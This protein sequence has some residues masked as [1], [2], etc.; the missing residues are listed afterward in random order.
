MPPEPSQRRPSTARLQPTTPDPSRDPAFAIEHDADGAIAAVHSTVRL[1]FPEA[2]AKGLVAAMDVPPGTQVVLHTR[3]T[4]TGLAR[5]KARMALDD[6]AI[7]AFAGLLGEAEAISQAVTLVPP[8][9]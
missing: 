8:G 3:L 1:A 6:D 5:F 7:Q 4:P 9:R 2:L